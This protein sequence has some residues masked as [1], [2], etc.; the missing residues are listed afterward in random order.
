MRSFRWNKRGASPKKGEMLYLT[1]AEA[2]ELAESLTR[3]VRTGDSN[4]DRAE[5][6]KAD[7]EYFSA[8]VDDEKA[9]E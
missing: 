7:G 1:K 3:Q 5:F 9:V 8:A 6:I 2:L 4:H